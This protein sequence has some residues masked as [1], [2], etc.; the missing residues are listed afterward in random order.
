MIIAI[1]A[2]HRGI[3]IFPQD[4]TMANNMKSK[5]QSA[6]IAEKFFKLKEKSDK[7]Y[8]QQKDAEI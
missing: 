2:E 5:K 3:Y 1:V 6:I 4:F 8:K 7:K